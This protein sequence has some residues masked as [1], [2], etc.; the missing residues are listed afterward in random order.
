MED[1]CRNCRF[2]E[3]VFQTVEH[4]HGRC[5][6]PVDAKRN[7]RNHEVFDTDTCHFFEWKGVS[8]D[9]KG[10]SRSH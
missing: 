10:K 2:Y 3:A 1:I 9:C 4:E 5:N 6:C 7:V 8:N